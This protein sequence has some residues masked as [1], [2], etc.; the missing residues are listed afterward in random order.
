MTPFWANYNYHLTMQFK[1]PKDPSLRSQ[2]QA[3]L[4]MAGVEVTHRILR[5]NIYGAQE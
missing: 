4:L 1:P 2:V 3:D 5:E